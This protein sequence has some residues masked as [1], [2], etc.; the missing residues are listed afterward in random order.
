MFVSHETVLPLGFA[1]ARKGLD[2][3][4]RGGWL[5]D[6]SGR[7]YD[8]GLVG[9]ARVGPFGDVLGASKIVRVSLLEPVPRE[10]T[11]VLPLRWEATGLMGRL[12]PVLDAN[13]SLTA[14]DDDHTTLTFTGAYRPP[15]AAVGT[16]IDRVLLHR[17][18]SATVRSLLLEVS[19]MIV[20][21]SGAPQPEPAG[22][23]PG[24]EPGWAESA[25]PA[26]GGSGAAGPGS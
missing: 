25:Q 21:L 2:E 24:L 5:R 17:A 1:A 15:L 4:A 11:M 23:C 10:G 22:A 9:L 13:L 19:Q 14:V 6:A 8:D 3:L 16:G 18:A 20:S 7:A 26:E 12:F